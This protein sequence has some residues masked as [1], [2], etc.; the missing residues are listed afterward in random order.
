MFEDVFISAGMK[1][2]YILWFSAGTLTTVKWAK[3]NKNFRLAI[4]GRDEHIVPP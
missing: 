2:S 3:M 4:I 1:G